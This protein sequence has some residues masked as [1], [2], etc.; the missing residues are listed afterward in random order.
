VSLVPALKV[1]GEWHRGYARIKTFLATVRDIDSHLTPEQKSDITAW[2]SLIEDLGDTL[3]V[4][5]PVNDPDILVEHILRLPPELHLLHS[6]G[7]GL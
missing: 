7:P 5:P 6:S 4:H 3:T 1:N 2:G